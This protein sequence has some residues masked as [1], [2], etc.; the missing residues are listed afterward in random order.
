MKPRQATWCYLLFGLLALNP[1][2]ALAEP[3][4]PDGSAEELPA[5]PTPLASHDLQ[6]Q[7]SCYAAYPYQLNLE[8]LAQLHANAAAQ[9]S[10]P[11]VSKHH[12]VQCRIQAQESASAY[13]LTE[14]TLTNEQLSP[15]NPAG[16]AVLGNGDGSAQMT[17]TVTAIPVGLRSL[18]LTPALVNGVLLH[19]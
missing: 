6:R 8:Q 13:Y 2:R 14:Q 4:L 16:A 1:A 18:A 7:G 15:P 5:Q 3:L 12:A 11:A 9:R 17:P 10:T 19:R